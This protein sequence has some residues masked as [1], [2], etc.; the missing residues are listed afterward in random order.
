MTSKQVQ[1]YIKALDPSKATGLDGLGPKIFKLAINSQGPIIAFLIN[2]TIHTGQFINE[3]NCAKV[4]PILRVEI[5]LIHRTLVTILST[6]SKLFERHVSKHLMI[7][8]NTSLFMN[9]NQAFVKNI[10]ARLHGQT[11]RSM[12]I[13][14]IKENL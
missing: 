10:A 13:V 4:F 7:L 6:I 3:M 8:L 1:S 2:K 11:D 9:I 12:D 5:N 14:L